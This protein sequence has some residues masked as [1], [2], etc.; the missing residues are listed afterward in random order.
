MRRS[1]LPG[2]LKLGSARGNPWRCGSFLTSGAGRNGKSA[3]SLSS[4]AA[5]ICSFLTGPCN[6]EIVRLAILLD[7]GVA[8]SSTDTGFAG[9]SLCLDDLHCP[10]RHQTVGGSWIQQGPGNEGLSSWSSKPDTGCHG[11]YCR[12]PGWSFV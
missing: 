1:I 4:T 10:G 9:Y 12:R 11:Q 6:D 8:T 7:E 3:V 2:T 5:V